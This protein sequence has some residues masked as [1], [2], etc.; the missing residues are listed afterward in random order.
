MSS[1]MKHRRPL[2]ARFAATL[3]FSCIGLLGLVC[4]TSPARAG[5]GHDHGD[6]APTATGAALPRF[7]AVSEAFELVGVLQG[8]QIT[9]YLD[10]FADNAPVRNAQIELDI[11]GSKLQARPVNGALGEGEYEVTLAPAPKP[12]LIAVTATVT[13]GAEVDL[14][15]GEFDLPD[16]AAVG[17]P[18]RPLRWGAAAGWAAAG[19]AALG[20]LAVGFRRVM[21][22]RRTRAEVAT[23]AAGAA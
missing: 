1:P 18:L 6:T 11:A 15:A 23:S 20:L 4:A 2:A 3:A 12:G 19:L 14:L 17:E 10:R 13:V 5:E 21:A 16:T 22:M 8:S 9:L 7:A